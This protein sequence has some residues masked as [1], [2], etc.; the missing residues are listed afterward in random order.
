MVRELETIFLGGEGMGRCSI[1]MTLGIIGGCHMFLQTKLS[2]LILCMQVL[3][4]CPEC[5]LYM[6]KHFGMANTKY[7]ICLYSIRP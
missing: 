3:L 1:L 2:V 7:L 5:I 4:S 6:S